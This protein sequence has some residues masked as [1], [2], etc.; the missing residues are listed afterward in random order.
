MPITP[1]LKGPY[2]F[3]L[4]TR[5][6]LGVAF[7]LV[8]ITLRTGDCDDHVKQAI[9]NKLIAL[10]KDGER[11]PD[12]LCDKALEAICRPEHVKPSTDAVGRSLV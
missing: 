1:Y 9:A 6:A 8:C 12:V 10:S 5:R 4:E 3:D 7:E 11:N 2:Y